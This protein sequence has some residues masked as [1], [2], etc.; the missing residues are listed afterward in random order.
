VKFKKLALG[1]GSALGASVLAMGLITAPA[2]AT[3]AAPT[4]EAPVSNWG[5][6][7]QIGLTGK[8]CVDPAGSKPADVVFDI[9]DAA[10]NPASY[11]YGGTDGTKWTA[12][13]GAAGIES[14]TDGTW[15][16]IAT[17]A[18]P[19]KYTVKM[20]CF[21]Y[22]SSNAVVEVGSASSPLTAY[23]LTANVMSTSSTTDNHF[24]GNEELTLQ[25]KGW[26]ANETVTLT[27]NGTKIVTGKADSKGVFIWT[28]KLPKSLQTAKE[29][30]FTLTGASGATITGTTPGAT[31]SNAAQK[32][33]SKSKVTSKQTG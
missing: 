3:P 1:V 18:T 15:A 11:T 30:S 33:T 31:S 19:G 4:F 20:G 22:N 27:V 8:N 23:A 7:P 2:N 6:T 10:G 13:N 14:P 26:G 16:V 5:T 9:T 21:T 12:E 25:S 32:V 24:Y 28:A 17:M 29:Y